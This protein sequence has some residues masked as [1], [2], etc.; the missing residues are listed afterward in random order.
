VAWVRFPAWE[1][2]PATGEVK[3]GRKGRGRGEEEEGREE[4]R[5]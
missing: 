2:Q 5:N 4:G 3:K 1:L